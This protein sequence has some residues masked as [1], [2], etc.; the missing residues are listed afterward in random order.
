LP[1]GLG[2]LLLAQQLSSQGCLDAERLPAAPVRSPQLLQATPDQ[3]QRELADRVVHGPVAQA[4]HDLDEHRLALVEAPRRTQAQLRPV[5]AGQQRVD[6]PGP[7]VGQQGPIVFLGGSE[8]VC[9]GLAVPHLVLGDMGECGGQVL[10]NGLGLA[11]L[12]LR[13]RSPSLAQQ[14]PGQVGVAAAQ[15][16]VVTGDAG[17]LPGQLLL[18]GEGFPTMLLHFPLLLLLGQ[19]QRQV[20]VANGQPLTV[21]GPGGKVGGQLRGQG[22]CLPI[23]RCRFRQSPGLLQQV[24]E[25]D[26]TRGPV[27]VVAGSAG[28]SAERAS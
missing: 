4:L 17:M 5:A 15:L 28:K 27:R 11:N 12:L 19:D 8:P 22:E 23:L 9:R 26:V 16:L 13:V 25:V 18:K 24:A 2:V 14:H 7:L 3:P 10:E 1:L 21:L 6:V 20:D